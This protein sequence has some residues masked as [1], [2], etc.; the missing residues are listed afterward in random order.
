MDR[1][2]ARPYEHLVELVVAILRVIGDLDLGRVFR[3]RPDVLERLGQAVVKAAPDVAGPA[4][5]QRA[6]ARIKL[7]ARFLALEAR[8]LGDRL[9]IEILEPGPQCILDLREAHASTEKDIAVDVDFDAH[10]S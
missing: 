10:H 6:L 7:D 8:R 3:K 2:G 4:H 1:L 9:D 5:R